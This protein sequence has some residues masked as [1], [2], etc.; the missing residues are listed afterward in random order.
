MYALRWTSW[1]RKIEKI[2]SPK[3]VF[4]LQLAWHAELYSKIS[5]F[6]FSLEFFMPNYLEKKKKTEVKAEF[7][8]LWLFACS[9]LHRLF[10]HKS[11]HGYVCIELLT[12][13]A[14]VVCCCCRVGVCGVLQIHRSCTS[15]LA[16]AFS[17]STRIAIRILA[18]GHTSHWLALRLPL[19]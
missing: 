2:L 8:D 4:S 18:L 3:A 9:C 19:L 7:L 17:S 16:C 1:T 5:N 10:L 15:S 13:L 12:C 11:F 14:V 6:S